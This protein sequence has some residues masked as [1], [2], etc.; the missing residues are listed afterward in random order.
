MSDAMLCFHGRQI[1]CGNRY[2]TNRWQVMLFRQ[3]MGVEIDRRT[4]SLIFF[5]IRYIYIYR[6]WFWYITLPQRMLSLPSMCFEIGTSF[7][8]LDSSVTHGKGVKWFS[9][10]LVVT[11]GPDVCRNFEFDCCFGVH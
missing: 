9:L 4:R 2:F 10:S 5:I 3:N 1:D 11:R 7:L 8:L 6:T